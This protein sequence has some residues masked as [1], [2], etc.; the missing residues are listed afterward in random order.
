MVATHGSSG[1]R[2]GVATFVAAGFALLGLLATR[3]VPRGPTHPDKPLSRRLFH[4]LAGGI[5]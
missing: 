5:P 1:H 3:I 4:R 2:T